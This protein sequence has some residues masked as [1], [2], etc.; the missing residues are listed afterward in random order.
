[1]QNF[2]TLLLRNFHT[3]SKTSSKTDYAP[4]SSP[5]TALFPY[6]VPHPVPVAYRIAKISAEYLDVTTMY[7]KVT[8]YKT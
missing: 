3:D 7:T 6:E 1:M 2:L 5:T 8:L 4:F